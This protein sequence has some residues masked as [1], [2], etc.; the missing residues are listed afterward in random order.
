MD[1]LEFKCAKCG[2]DQLEQQVLHTKQLASKVFMLEGKGIHIDLPYRV[3]ELGYE[4][5]YACRK[6]GDFLEDQNLD[7]VRTIDGLTK[8]LKEHQDG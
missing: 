6:C 7:L 3:F 2:H 5:S 8:W 4:I 1:K